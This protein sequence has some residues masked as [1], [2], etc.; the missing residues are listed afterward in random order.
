MS[1]KIRP[2]GNKRTYKNKKT[3]R[4][5]ASN[6]IKMTNDFFENYNETE[7]NK[8]RLRKEIREEKDPIAKEAKNIFDLYEQEKNIQWDFEWYSHADKEYDMK[9]SIAYTYSDEKYK[10]RVYIHK[11]TFYLSNK[12]HISRLLDCSNWNVG[13][14]VLKNK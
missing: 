7:L 3:K 9:L 14:L 12:E 5:D 4:D 6:F 8:E 1:K 13:L 11:C 2:I 10:Y